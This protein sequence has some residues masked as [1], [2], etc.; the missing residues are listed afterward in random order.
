MGRANTYSNK[1]IKPENIKQTKAHN[2][3]KYSSNTKNNKNG[4]GNQWSPS[5]AQKGANKIFHRQTMTNPQIHI[6]REKEIRKSLPR[7]K[8]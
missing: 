4:G 6:K 1:N 3:A 5:P 2:K 8:V 7:K